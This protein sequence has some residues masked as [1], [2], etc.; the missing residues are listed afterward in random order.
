MK[1]ILWVTLVLIALSC[2]KSQ[3]SENGQIIIGKPK[4][5]M[6]DNKLTPEILWSF[7]RIGEVALSPDK[8]QVIFSVKYFDIT[9]NKGNSDVYIMNTDSTE[10]KQI[11]RSVK[12]EANLQ[13]RPDGLK[14]GFLYSDDSGTQL[15][16]MDSDGSNRTKISNIEGGITGFKYAPNQQLVVYSR[17]LKNL[18]EQVK[19][20]HPDLPKAQAYLNDDLMYRHWDSWTESYSHLFF[21]EY[22]GKSLLNA[23]DIMEGEKFDAPNKPFGGMEQVA[24]S[25]DSKSLVYSSVKKSGAAYAVS[26]NSDLYLYSLETRQTTNLTEGM[27]G[28][29]QNPV[30]SPD[31]KLLAWE[32]MARD[33]YESDKIRLF[34]RDIASGI[35]TEYTQN[36]DQNVH[37]LAWNNEGNKIYFTSDWHA[38]YQVYEFDLNKKT[39]RT[40]TSGDYNYQSVWFAGDRLVATRMSISSPTE[41][42]A[43]SLSDNSVSQLSQV[44]TDLLAKLEM[45][46]VEERWIKTT[47]AKEMLTWVIYPPDFDSSK[48]YPA[49]LYCQ[50]GPQSSVSQFFSYRWNFQIMAANGYIVV[51]PNRRGVPSFGQA[52]NEQ[53][54]GDWSGQNMKDYLSAI[55]A[56]AAEPFVDENRLGAAGASYGGYSVYWLAGN[57]NKRFKAFLS[58]DGT[59]NLE[60][61]YLETEEIWFPNWEFKGAFWEKENAIA[62]KTYAGSPHKFV[63]NWDTPIMIV[64]GEKDYRI[65][66]TQGVQAFTAARLKGIPARYLHFPE[67]NHWVL[68]PQ[69]GILWQREY[70]RWFDEWLK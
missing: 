9:E 41:I 40:L 12:S 65:P 4:V 62:Q 43:V 56:V 17:E 70:F 46:K 3:N 66:Y 63:Q 68:G 16:E 30:F 23:A 14:I 69:N 39:F 22:D 57:H 60:S 51:A 11:T 20:R 25:P 42:Y 35:N 44:N 6:T 49:I 50:G 61:M 52:W 24:W 5:T 34:V 27:N 36:F 21:A 33:G 31:G 26:T 67:E 28:Y 32:S 47:D 54:S 59:F 2:N 18:K 29:D 64:H 15:W 45:G 19:D 58:H 10:T 8:K 38:R 7:G 48:K 13:W 55:D 1:N 53:I 37:G